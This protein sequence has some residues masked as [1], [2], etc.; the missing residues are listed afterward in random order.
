MK[1]PLLESVRAKIGRADTHLD[2][3]KAALSVA[4]DS[5]TN[6][7]A[8]LALEQ[9]YEGQHLIIKLKGSQKPTPALPLL[10]GDCI[11]NLRS[12]LDHL[13]YQLALQN[14]AAMKAA[15]QTFFPIYLTEAK[16]N[17]RVKSLVKP[18]IS[19]T[20]LTEIVKC[21]P[22][23]AYDVPEEA[24]I[25]IL[26]QLDIIDKH[27][28]LVVADQKVAVTKFTVIVPTGERFHQ[29]MTELKWKPMKDGTELLRFDLSKPVPSQVDVHV[30]LMTTVQIDK[31]G[32]ACDGIVLEDALSQSSALVHAIVRDF[33]TEFFDE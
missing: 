7:E 26:S 17:E 2:N 21:Q 5:S 10:I 6:A 11:H 15:E 3:I 18:H 30:Q 23:C 25:W 1:S 13:V 22:Y 20:A 33:G 16:F 29:V 12:A 19:S 8:P 24:D 28:L 32:L 9:E 31:T 14:G 27:R 4:L